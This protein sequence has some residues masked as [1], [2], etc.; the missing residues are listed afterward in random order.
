MSA[1]RRLRLSRGRRRALHASAGLPT[2]TIEDGTVVATALDLAV[3][4]MD[5]ADAPH[6]ARTAHGEGMVRFDRK[7]I[8]AAMAAG[9]DGARE[10]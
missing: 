6:L 2:V 10:A 3:R 5:C 7:F 4:D 1:A 9:Y 8:K